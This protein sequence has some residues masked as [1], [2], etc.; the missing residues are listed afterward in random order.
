M[1]ICII[2]SKCFI[3]DES[4]VEDLKKIGDLAL[5]DGIPESTDEVVRLSL[6]HI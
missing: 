5:Y 6:I 3:S 4:M 2:D 1:K